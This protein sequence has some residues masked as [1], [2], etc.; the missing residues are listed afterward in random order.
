V[1]LALWITPRE[2]KLDPAAELVAPNFDCMT[3][4]TDRLDY[5]I[6]R[7]HF[8][9][10]PAGEKAIVYKFYSFLVLHSGKNGI[11]VLTRT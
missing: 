1:A 8:A 4:E 7:L 2:A 9:F 6:F 5:I 3:V 10:P 11:G